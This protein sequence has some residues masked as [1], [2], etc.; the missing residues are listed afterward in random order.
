V[1]WKGTLKVL[2]VWLAAPVVVALLLECGWRLRAPFNRNRWPARFDARVGFLFDPDS[3]VDWTNHVDFWVSSRV[4]HLGFLDREP[5]V[6]KRPNSCRV[7]ILGD[8]FV[9]AAQVPLEQRLQSVLGDRAR[10]ELGLDLDVVAMGYSGTGQVNQLAFYDTF[11]KTLEPD[12]IA[13]VF[14]GND[15]ANNSAILESVR[16]GW[17]PFHPPRPELQRESNGEI[18][19]I[20]IDPA[21]EKW[22]LP[23]VASRPPLKLHTRLLERSYFYPWAYT[24]LSSQYPKI[25]EVLSGG[26]P[27][28]ALY[29]ARIAEIRQLE[30]LARA[31]DGWRFP[32]DLDF[33][34]MFYAADPLPPLFEA[35]LAESDAAFAAFKA[36]AEER[37]AGLVVLATYGVS[38]WAVADTFGRTFDPRGQ[39]VRLE[40]MLKARGIPLLDQQAAIAK[41]GGKTADAHFSRDG[42]WS[43]QGHRWAAAAL[44][45]YLR[46]NPLPCSKR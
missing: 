19:T 31:F 11:G 17:H 24:H 23:K 3:E 39:F 42:H 38:T 22:T 29:T 27:V 7:L 15:F 28:A 18:R 30:G 46:Q 26:A 37:G 14:V 16:N 35:A 8:S 34:S 12:L 1:A 2:A 43:P 33:D 21:W 44:L 45:E 36:R 9:E 10:T 20:P 5:P 4:N 40:A 32:N 6:E 25:A 41:A 13:L